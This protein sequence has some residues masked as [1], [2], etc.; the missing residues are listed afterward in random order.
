MFLFDFLVER[1]KFR[2]LRRRRIV[3][4]FLVIDQSYSLQG[5]RISPNPISV[6]HSLPGFREN[7][8][9]NFFRDLGRSDQSGICPLTD[10][11]V[12]P[13]DYVGTL[14]HLRSNWE[15]V[16]NLLGRPDRNFE[17][18]IVFEF[19]GS[20]LKGVASVRIHPD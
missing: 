5:D 8:V 6:K 15:T 18:E 12:R 17:S 9:S 16:C 19:F 14:R 3:E 11:I 4:K 2:K 10:L 7:L 1:Y 13:N 20:R